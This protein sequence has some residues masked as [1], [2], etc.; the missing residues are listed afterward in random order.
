MPSRRSCAPPWRRDAFF[1]DVRALTAQLAPVAALHGLAQV[2]LKLAVPGVPDIYQGCELWDFSL[3]DP[4]NRRAVDYDR[5]RDMLGAFAARDDDRAALLDELLEAWPD[6]RIKLYVTWRMLQWRRAHAATFLAEPIA[7]S[8]SPAPERHRWSRSRATNSSSP[9]RASPRARARG[10]RLAYGDER[11]SLGRPDA[12][13]H[14]VLDGRS[15]TTDAAAILRRVRR[16][17]LRRWRCWRPVSAADPPHHDRRDDDEDD[18]ADNCQR[19]IVHVRRDRIDVV[20]GFVA[21]S[22]ESEAKDRRTE[23]RVVRK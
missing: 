18:A 4:D 8:T 6:G 7:R 12:V 10:L 14:N 1:R 2:A 13:Y 3:V 23:C 17:P 11:I 21:E 22:G 20:P 5:R 19:K 16:L 15:I 9:R